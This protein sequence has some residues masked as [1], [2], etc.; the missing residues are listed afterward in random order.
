VH[1]IKIFWLKNGKNMPKNNLDEIAINFKLKEILDEIVTLWMKT[2]LQT[3]D[4]C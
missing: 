2:K 1:Q 4:M 3:C